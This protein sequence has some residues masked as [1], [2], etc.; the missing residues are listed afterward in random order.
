MNL[1]L[2]EQYWRRIAMIVSIPFLIMEC[3]NTDYKL[4]YNKFKMDWS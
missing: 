1:N 2:I 4:V 3:L